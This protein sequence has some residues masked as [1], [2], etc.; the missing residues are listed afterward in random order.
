VS[1]RRACSVILAGPD[2]TEPA[3]LAIV[4]Q[5]GIVTPERR[6]Q[7]IFSRL[8]LDAADRLGAIARSLV[9]GRLVTDSASAGDKLA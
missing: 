5:I 4:R 7:W 8:S 1:L 2:P 6:G 3:G 9:P